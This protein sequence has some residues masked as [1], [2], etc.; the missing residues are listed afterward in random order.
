MQEDEPNKLQTPEFRT[1][2]VFKAAEIYRIKGDLKAKKRAEYLAK[3]YALKK[4]R[5]EMAYQAKLAKDISR[6]F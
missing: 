3:R 4:K 6:M 5:E 1:P 2:Q